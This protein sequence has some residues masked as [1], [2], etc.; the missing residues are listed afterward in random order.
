[1]DSNLINDK[2]FGSTELLRLKYRRGGQIIQSFCKIGKLG[3]Q[4]L[5]RL[6]YR[7]GGPNNSVILQNWFSPEIRSPVLNLQKFEN[8]ERSTSESYKMHW[9]LINGKEFGSKKN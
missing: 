7:S 3:P 9:K 2:E 8:P 6:K 5:L 1:M 4:K